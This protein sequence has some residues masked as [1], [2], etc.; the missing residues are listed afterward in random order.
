MA[1]SFSEARDED[2]NYV[3]YSEA[4]NES[5]DLLEN[6]TGIYSQ[7]VECEFH[8][9]LNILKNQNETIQININLTSENPEIE[10]LEYLNS[11][12]KINSD[13]HYNVYQQ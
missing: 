6:E 2:S 3:Q 12:V 13:G 7:Q 8:E 5:I 10:L 4:I 9:I 1:A 11:L